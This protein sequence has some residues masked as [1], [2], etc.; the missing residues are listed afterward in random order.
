M[1]DIK[2]VID[3]KGRK[4]KA[5]VDPGIPTGAYIVIGPLEGLVDTLGLPEEVATR[6]HNILYDREILD[7]KSLSRRGIAQAVI[8]ELFSVDANRLMD[9]FMKFENET[10]G[11]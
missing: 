3:E 8:Q 10:T 9:A 1:N 11:G 7:V 4:Y 2:E 5:Y 6:L